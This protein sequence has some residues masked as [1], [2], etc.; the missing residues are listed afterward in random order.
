MRTI[1]IVKRMA[2]LSAALVMA[3]TVAAP[4]TMITGMAADIKVNTSTSTNVNF[5]NFSAYQIFAGTYNSTEG[6]L[7]VTG[8]GTGV[9]STKLTTAFSG[10]TYFSGCT[11]AT[12][13]ADVLSGTGTDSPE[14]KEFAKCI[15]KALSA[16]TSGTYDSESKTITGLADG[17]YIVVAG[18]GETEDG[19]TAWSSGLLQVAGTGLTTAEVTPK[20]DVASVEKK[21]Y[22]D[23][24]DAWQDIADAE[25]QQDV[26][27]RLYAT[28]PSNYD[29]YNQY[30]LQFKDQLDGGFSS[31]GNVKYYVK[32]GETVTDLTT[33]KITANTADVGAMTFT[34]TNLKEITELGAGD[35]L[36][37]EYTAK[38]NEGAIV[39]P[40]TGND[41]AVTLVY[42][43]NPTVDVDGTQTPGS[44]ENPTGETPKDEVRVLTYQLDVTKIDGVTNATLADAKFKLQRAEDNKW[45]TLDSN[46]KIT[47]WVTSEGDATE[48]T[49]GSDG[50]FTI[51]GFDEGTYS[52]TETVAPTDYNL[53]ADSFDVIIASEFTNTTFATW[54]ADT[55]PLSKLTLN[56]LG[57]YKDTGIITMDIENTKGSSLPETGGMGTT[58]F[59]FAGGAL[60]IGSGVALIAKKR[61][62]NKDM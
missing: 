2:T 39:T 52:L 4:A 62:K 14:A 50:K 40:T 5:S 33:D 43:N 7:T 28:L 37:V 34:C 26:K 38:L 27:F 18:E 23:S 8:W 48:I 25:M 3:A 22:E 19:R 31:V 30:Y 1:N 46:G 13:Y 49:S 9:D 36:I 32:S 11:T 6:N 29:E 41:N 24:A 59:Y 56:G 16:T 35:T 57:E 58:L 15:N 21:V 10:S 42:S 44:E 51:T 60:V 53:P 20:A 54:G 45:A 55:N 17:Y 47:G 12:D 61:M